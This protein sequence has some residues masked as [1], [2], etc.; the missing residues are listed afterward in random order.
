MKTTTFYHNTD[1]PYLVK[2]VFRI[3]GGSFVF[4][5][6]E[7]YALAKSLKR[8]D[9]KKR[10]VKGREREREVNRLPWC[11]FAVSKETEKPEMIR[12][13]TLPTSNRQ[14]CQPLQSTEYPFTGQNYSNTGEKLRLF[15]S[16]LHGS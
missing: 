11:E 14:H 15:L 16:F 10:R 2:T 6:L 13:A 8:I 4:S 3:R 9:W 12:L 5:C 1:V 7:V